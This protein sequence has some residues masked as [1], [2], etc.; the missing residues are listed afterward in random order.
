MILRQSFILSWFCVFILV[1]C[2]NKELLNEEDT[3]IL[4]EENTSVEVSKNMR[5]LDDS[6]NSFDS[7]IPFTVVKS[8]NP[9]EEYIEYEEVQG[10]KFTYIKLPKS[11]SIISGKLT[12]EN[13]REDPL[14]IKTLFFQGNENI[15]IKPQNSSEWTSS[16][17]YEVSPHSSHTINID[18]KWDVNGMQELTFFPID[19]TSE[20]EHYNGGNLGSF[21]FFVQ[22]KDITLSK[23]S[24]NEQAFQLDNN[25]LKPEQDV[26]PV[27]IWV[28][29]NNDEVEF[30]S[31]GSILL[32]KEKVRGIKLSAIPY[33]TEVDIVLV[34]E[35]GNSSLISKGVKIVKDQPTTISFNHDVLEKMYSEDARQFL[36]I[37][38]NREE[39]ILSDLKALNLYQKPFFTSHQRV[40]EFYKS[41]K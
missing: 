22:S 39:K 9:N 19:Q 38:N 4:N 10:E 23:E 6:E 33:D 5:I 11:K 1:G 29:E 41:E 24:V 8:F 21:R 7:T 37:M 28:G 3:L 14:I 27:P 12:F 15:K 40:I 18:L 30:S 36:L 2:Q 16:I 17:T 32:T 13:D 25:E 20:V 31:K 35:F 26:F 34:D